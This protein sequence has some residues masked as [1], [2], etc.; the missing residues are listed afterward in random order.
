MKMSETETIYVWPNG[1]W[2]SQDEAESYS[3]M[4]DDY[5]VVYVPQEWGYEEIDNYVCN[6]GATR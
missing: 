2:C 6:R 3:H 5:E 1:T 4:S